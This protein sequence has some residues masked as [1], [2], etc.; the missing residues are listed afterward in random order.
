MQR[1]SCTRLKIGEAEERKKPK[2]GR[3][4]PERV[5]LKKKKFS[6]ALMLHSILKHLSV[7]PSALSVLGG[8]PK[9]EGKQRAN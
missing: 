5:R 3:E 4:R 2:R 1:N 7:R 6:M 9:A 8:V